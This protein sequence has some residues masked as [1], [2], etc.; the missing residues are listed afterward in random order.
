MNY[1]VEKIKTSGA[2][3]YGSRGNEN[4][5]VFKDGTPLRPKVVKALRWLG[6]YFMVFEES[7]NSGLYLKRIGKSD[8]GVYV[9]VCI[10]SK[11]V[12]N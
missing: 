5:L 7:R 2:I 1:Q 4:Q 8:K 12:Y 6:S 10:W 3:F 11:L 9:T